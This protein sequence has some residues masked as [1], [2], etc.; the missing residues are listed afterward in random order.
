MHEPG[1]FDILRDGA[2]MNVK[3]VFGLGAY[4]MKFGWNE[5]HRA[6]P[7]S[8]TL[9]SPNCFTLHSLS[10]DAAR[11]CLVMGASQVHGTNPDLPRVVWSANVFYTAVSHALRLERQFQELS[12]KEDLGKP[13]AG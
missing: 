11:R 10:G 12:L 7:V 13:C 6:P 5:M 1:S 2:C 9:P 4:M 3:P 8:S